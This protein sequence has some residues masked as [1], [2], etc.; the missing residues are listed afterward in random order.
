M[1]PAD[2]LATMYHRRWTIEMFHA[3]YVEKDNL[4]RQAGVD[5]SGG[6]GVIEAGALVPATHGG[7]DRRIA[8][9]YVR[10]DRVPPRAGSGQ[11]SLSC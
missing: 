10:E 4:Y 7:P 5:Y 9:R 3:D 6:S 11:V 8:M 2:E 1:Y